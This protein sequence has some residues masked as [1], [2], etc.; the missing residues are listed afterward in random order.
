MLPTALFCEA[1]LCAAEKISTS[2][3]PDGCSTA[4]GILFPHSRIRRQERVP[5]T[6]HPI[7]RGGSTTKSRLDSQRSLKTSNIWTMGRYQRLRRS[8]LCHF[9]IINWCLAAVPPRLMFIPF[10]FL[11][12]ALQAFNS[13]LQPLLFTASVPNDVPE[14]PPP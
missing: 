8:A 4:S 12:G 10:R 6:Q 11:P 5:R 7:H 13:T 3:S 14:P 9:R 1:A 2:A